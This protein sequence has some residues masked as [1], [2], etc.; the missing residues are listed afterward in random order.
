[1]STIRLQAKHCWKC[2]TVWTVTQ[3]WVMGRFK[4]SS[5]LFSNNQVFCSIAI[6]PL[7]ESKPPTI[8]HNLN[9]SLMGGNFFI[10]RTCRV[11]PNLPCSPVK[12][13]WVCNTDQ[14]LLIDADPPSFIFLTATA[15]LMKTDEC[16]CLYW[17]FCSSMY[18]MG[19]TINMKITS[20]F[21]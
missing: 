7:W 20:D 18:L 17:C 4:C 13:R 12:C 16:G 14:Y 10:I 9:T 3:S 11:F 5:K 6:I 19:S 15:A 2:F 1:M 21:K 8:F